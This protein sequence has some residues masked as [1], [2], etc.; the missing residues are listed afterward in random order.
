MIP[1]ATAV[2]KLPQGKFRFFDWIDNESP[3]V[4]PRVR[5]PYE[6]LCAGEDRFLGMLV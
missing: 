3:L 4:K 1:R 2:R 5:N 6:T